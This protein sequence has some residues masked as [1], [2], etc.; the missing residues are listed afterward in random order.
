VVGSCDYLL[1]ECCPKDNTA[2]ISE[3]ILQDIEVIDLIGDNIM[4]RFL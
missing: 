1:N 3:N 4:Q 2:R